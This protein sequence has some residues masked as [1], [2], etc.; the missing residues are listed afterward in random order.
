M[1]LLIIGLFLYQNP[2]SISF[3][4]FDTRTVTV[5]QGL[6]FASSSILFMF[7]WCLMVTTIAEGS[8]NLQYECGFYKNRLFMF[9]FTWLTFVVFLTTSCLAVNRESSGVT[10][11]HF[12]KAVWHISGVLSV[13]FI[14]LFFGWLFVTIFRA[15][16]ALRA[17]PYMETRA[18]QISLRL[19]LHQ[20]MVLFLF[21]AGFNIYV[22]RAKG[23][24]SLADPKNTHLTMLLLMSNYVWLLCFIYLPASKKNLELTTRNFDAHL[25]YRM[26]V[27]AKQ[28]YKNNEKDEEELEMEELE[29]E[30]LGL[31][32]LKIVNN[33]EKD[34]KVVICK[35]ETRRPKPRSSMKDLRYLEGEPAEFV[36]AFRGSVSKKNLHTNLEITR[37]VVDPTFWFGRG[38][39]KPG[40]W[41][42]HGLSQ[43]TVEMF[44]RDHIWTTKIH[45]GF[46]EAWLAVQS[47]VVGCLLNQL[48]DPMTRKRSRLFIC[49]HSLGGALSQICALQLKFL[50]SLE[51]TVV[52]FGSPRVGGIRFSRLLDKRVPGNFRVVMLRDPVPT[53]PKAIP[54]YK[55]AG[56]ECR[57]DTK[58]NAIIGPLWSEKKMLPQQNSL[59]HHRCVT[60]RDGLATLLEQTYKTKRKRL[61]STDFLAF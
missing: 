2:F 22:I 23:W 24:F 28:M 56:I 6:T 3:E 1:G 49:G 10:S 54:R 17:L 33:K 44:A 55:H 48:S 8:L 38:L 59:E 32:P 43:E 36:I 57:I 29:L 14:L 46:Y 30:A 27:L 18:R 9:F 11:S 7:Y 12:F 51:V 53:V 50:T 13:L 19:F 61:V 26:S 47:E 34:V 60:Y 5:Y 52:T 39:V 42:R 35:R 20:T 41:E 37:Q 16:K 31:K 58:G 15:W 40:H 45:R 21:L 4:A 25:A